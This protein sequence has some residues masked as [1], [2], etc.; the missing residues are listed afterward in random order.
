[1]TDHQER[2]PSIKDPGSKDPSHKPSTAPLAGI[3]LPDP[4]SIAR[5][6]HV[7]DLLL[8]QIKAK[9]GIDNEEL[10]ASL[11][12]S[13]EVPIE[14]ARN[15]LATFHML[16][17]TIY[18]EDH[19]PFQYTQESAEEIRATSVLE[20]QNEIERAKG[21]S[22]ISEHYSATL[23]CLD[24][25][26]FEIDG[27]VATN[28]ANRN[29]KDAVAYER[30]SNF[31][32]GTVCDGVSRANNSEFGAKIIS[33]LMTGKIAELLRGDFQSVVDPNSTDSV[34]TK[35]FLGRVH[36]EL[37]IAFLKYTVRLGLNPEDSA[38]NVFSTTLSVL[39]VT[40]RETVILAI[41]DGNYTLNNRHAEIKD[42]IHRD[43]K[44]KNIPEIFGRTYVSLQAKLGFEEDGK[45]L[46]IVGVWNTNEIKRVGIF[47]DGIRFCSDF[48]DSQGLAYYRALSNEIGEIV[49]GCR[50]NITKEDLLLVK[51]AIL[52]HPTMDEVWDQTPADITH[53]IESGG[54]ALLMR[55][56][57]KMI[58]ASWGPFLD[59]TS[60]IRI[61]RNLPL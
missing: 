12:E 57:P 34:L 46:R 30:E 20:A 22:R 23:P 19:S 38:L 36:A 9:I 17:D 35:E 6:E 3:C 15:A 53:K 32:I 52:K 29:P 48:I 28:Y 56:L 26:E 7:H 10:I 4:F 40:P 39:I 58:S 13:I 47:T 14:A 37:N 59:D 27:F 50:P 42:L 5:Y 55:N 44:G 61:Y 33:S 21:D 24:L 43:K 45:A 1:M 54:D 60:G 31:I 16:G 2:N 51:S 11:S 18:H 8:D 25:R 41:G 49:R